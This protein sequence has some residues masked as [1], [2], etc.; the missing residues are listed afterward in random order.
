[1]R[2]VF[3]DSRGRTYFFGDY[4]GYREAPQAQSYFTLPTVR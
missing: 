4:E 3:Y 1:V 2:P